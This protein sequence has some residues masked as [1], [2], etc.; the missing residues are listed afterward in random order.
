M[1]RDRNSWR[2]KLH[3]AFFLGADAFKEAMR[4]MEALGPDAPEKLRQEITDRMQRKVEEVSMRFPN[5]KSPTQGLL[6]SSSSDVRLNDLEHL[7]WRR[8]LRPRHQDREAARADDL[9]AFNRMNR[10]H[11]DYVRWRRGQKVKDFRIDATH[12]TLLESG[13]DLGLENLTSEELA[14]CFD[15]VCPCNNHPHDADALKKQRNRLRK[16]V[17]E[18]K[19]NV[20]RELL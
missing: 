13:F 2:G 12:W 20:S 9:D 17:K 10:T 14:D 6:Y 19:R 16:L 11:Q 18:A 8:H 15:A 4:A 5:L 7:H 1:R 3:E